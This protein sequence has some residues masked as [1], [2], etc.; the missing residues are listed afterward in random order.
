MKNVL[1]AA[2]IIVPTIA[3]ADNHGP[4]GNLPYCGDTDSI[5]AHMDGPECLIWDGDNPARPDPEP[6]HFIDG[7]ELP[8]NTIVVDEPLSGRALSI[9]ADQRFGSR[10]AVAIIVPEPASCDTHFCAGPH[11]RWTAPW[12]HQ[13]GNHHRSDEDRAQ[14]VVD[15]TAAASP[16]PDRS[17]TETPDNPNPWSGDNKNDGHEP[18]ERSYK[19]KHGIR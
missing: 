1:A 12:W 6:T 9:I 5:A 18:S 3:L 13:R 19:D 15:R 17:W 10:D 2:L 4:I 11:A 8:M 7:H 14:H 16:Q